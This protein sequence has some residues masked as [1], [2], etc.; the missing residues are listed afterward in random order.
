ML[1]KETKRDGQAAFFFDFF[2]VF[3]AAGF[4]VVVF[5][6]VFFLAGTVSL[7]GTSIERL[8]ANTLMK[9]DKLHGGYPA[10]SKH[11][12]E[13]ATKSCL[14]I[15]TVDA[16]SGDTTTAVRGAV[17]GTSPSRSAD[18]LRARGPRPGAVRRHLESEWRG[19]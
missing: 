10:R 4:F 16:R 1:L 19:P 18:P 15:R 7:L 14:W 12:K 9:M 11:V 17:H 5:F 13:G 2:A 6:V 8:R 3:F